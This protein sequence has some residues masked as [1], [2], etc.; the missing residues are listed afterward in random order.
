MEMV[1]GLL[2]LLLMALFAVVVG[3]PVIVGRAIGQVW[4]SGWLYVMT[5][6]RVFGIPAADSAGPVPEPPRHNPENGREPAYEQYLFAQ[7][8]RDLVLALKRVY[9]QARSDVPVAA[10][11]IVDRYMDGSW[12]LGELWLRLVGLMLLAGLYLGTLVSVFL[13][14]AVTLVQL[15]I[16]VA[17]AAVGV[18]A[19]LA[20]RA[21]DSALLRIKGIR[22]TCP[23]CYRHIAY[24]SYRCPGCGAWH[25]D[26]RPGRYGVLRRRCSCVEERLPTLLILGSHRLTAFCPYPGCEVQLA[27]SSG[28]AAETLLAFFGGSNAGKTRLLTVMLMALK[29][30]DA[31]GQT[32]ATYADRMTARR[33]GELMPAVIG[34]LPTP[35]TGPDQPRAYSL[36]L[37]SPGKKNRRIVHLFDTGGEKFVDPQKVAALEYFRSAST[38]IFVIDPF[39]IDRVWDG[40]TPARQSEL[41]PRGE[42]SPAYI[43]QQVVQNVEEMRVDLKRVRL[44]VA[45]SKADMLAAEQL[46]APGPGS[47]AVGQWL[48]EMGLDHVV[49]SMR[50]GFGEVR[51]FHTSAML[52]DSAVPVSVVD[53][54]DW[55]LAGSGPPD[56]MGNG[57]ALLG[58]GAPAEAGGAPGATDGDAPAAEDGD[59]PAAGDKDGPAKAGR[60]ADGGDG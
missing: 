30:G 48:D 58:G 29:D 57:Q 45:V 56:E 54:L 52:T 9:G 46:P 15:L 41:S 51:F 44:G 33:V 6:A 59:A 24:P 35:H 8:R 12:L 40:L 11:R 14:A 50:H 27:D 25:H 32:V 21:A 16:A 26:I 31:A 19:I 60:P 43:F 3:P 20:L 42:H 13:L 2:Y 22:V 5:F 17:L 39:S 53:L 23:N 49:R 37:D 4:G 7:V 38:F 36:Y 18:S 47:A 34:N 55:V 28:T 1:G 10:R